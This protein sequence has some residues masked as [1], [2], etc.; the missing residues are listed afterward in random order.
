MQ[1][2]ADGLLLSASDLVAFM[3]CKHLAAL[4]LRAV[5]GVETIAVSR[6]DTALLVARKGDE[7][8]RAYLERILAESADVVV[9]PTVADGLGDLHE[10]VDR[11]TKAMR[12]GAEVIYQGALLTATGVDMR[13]SSNA[14][15][16]PSPAFG[17]YSYEVLDTKL[18][19]TARSRATSSSCACTS[20][21]LARVQGRWPERMHVVLRL[22]R[23]AQLPGG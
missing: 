21:L 6:D 5:R 8:E 4:D 20:E 16:A 18:A 10:A 19:R 7:H 14:L 3:E 23:A 9:V 17:D 2:T 1:L 12:A 11:T 13:T 22:G 15:P